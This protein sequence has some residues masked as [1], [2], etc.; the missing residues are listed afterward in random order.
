MGRVGTEAAREAADIVLVD[1]AFETIV[2][3]IR[4]GRRIA[5]NVRNVIAF[6][7]SANLG[8]VVLFA[9]AVTAGLG[10]PMAV[11]QVLAVNVLTD[12]LPALALARDPATPGAM[13]RPPRA[14]GTFL[15][16]D[17]M[18][19]LGV[20]GALVGLVG[21]AAFLVG[22]E[23]D[24][25]SAQTMA[26]VTVALAEL[27]FVFACRSETQLAWRAPWNGYLVLGVLAS[28]AIVAAIVYV[29]FLNAPFA[30]VPL[31]AVELI[32]AA[33]L[34]LVPAAGVELA[35]LL[36]RSRPPRALTA[37]L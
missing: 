16:G 9:I 18:L 17:V 36:R 8:E 31:G 14:R 35:K 3:A 13:L 12:G 28:A 5:D 37:A 2:A 26:F 22:R 29:P 33:G 30:T 10:A 25:S 21:L 34:A 23:L 11:V 24:A 27:V 6:L 1:D 19:A 20:A 15:P 7:L 32:V 4:E